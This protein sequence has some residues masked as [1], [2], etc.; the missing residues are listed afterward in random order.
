MVLI[1]V[2]VLLIVPMGMQ[3][4]DRQSI[5]VDGVVST[6]LGTPRPVSGWSDVGILAIGFGLIALLIAI[7]P[8][9]RGVH[10]WPRR[11]FVGAATTLTV[12]S[13]LSFSL[14][15]FFFPAALAAWIPVLSGPRT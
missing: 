3:V 6:E 10:P 14:G 13:V 5:S 15:V 4:T 8:L 7:A 2:A 12:L 1:G 9:G 11:G